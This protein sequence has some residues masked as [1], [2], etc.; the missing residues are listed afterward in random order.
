[1]KNAKIANSY[2]K[3]VLH[4]AQDDQVKWFF[5]YGQE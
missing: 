2:D 5:Q 3:Q 4:C 1:M